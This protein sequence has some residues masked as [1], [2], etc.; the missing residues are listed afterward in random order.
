M[1]SQGPYTSLLI[2][3]LTY[4][5]LLAAMPAPKIKTLESTISKSTIQELEKEL[6]VRTPLVLTNSFCKLSHCRSTKEECLRVFAHGATSVFL[7]P[8]VG[9]F[10]LVVAEIN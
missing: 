4:F 2:K 6:D 5:H 10:W 8:C 7:Q 1:S 3:I 9:R